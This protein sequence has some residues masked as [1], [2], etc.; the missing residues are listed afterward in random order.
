M[1]GCVRDTLL[2]RAPEDWDVT[3]AARPEQIAALFARLASPRDCGTG[4]SR[5]AGETAIEVTTFRAD[6]TYS[7]HRRPDAGVFLRLGWRRICA[8]AT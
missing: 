6:G 4:R 5:P 7:D 1:G 8:A 2:G 3:T